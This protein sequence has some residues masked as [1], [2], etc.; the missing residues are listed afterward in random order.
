MQGLIDPENNFNRDRDR[1]ENILSEVRQNIF[2]Q[3]ITI[4]FLFWRNMTGK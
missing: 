1:V 4:Q 3:R 2:T